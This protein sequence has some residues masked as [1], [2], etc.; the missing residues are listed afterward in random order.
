MSEYVNVSELNFKLRDEL[1]KYLWEL[2]TCGGSDLH[3]KANSIIRKRVNGEIIKIDDERFLSQSE[4][5]TLAK[6][7]L[8]GRF[9]ELVTKKSVDF[10]Y[11]PLN[12]GGKPNENYRFRVNIFFQMDGTSAV[13]RTI[14][15]QIPSLEKLGLPSSIRQICENTYRG[16]VLVTGPTGSGKSTTLASMIDFIN[17]RRKS[18]IITIEDPIEFVHSDKECVINQRS[19]GQDAID[20]ASALRGALREDPD[21]ILVG[22]MRDL[23][24]IEIAMRAAETGH[25]VLST[26]HTVDAK[27][28]IK[29]IIG[30]FPGE[31]QN[32]IRLTI[33]S[34]VKGIISQRLCKTTDHS[35]VAAIEV[36]LQTHRIS[37]LILNGK[38]EEIYDAMIES[39]KDSGMQT[40]DAHLLELYKAKR[41]TRAE[42]LENASKRDDL[43]GRLDLVDSAQRVGEIQGGAQVVADDEKVFSLKKVFD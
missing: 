22:E 7:L 19:V 15:V 5:L 39:A 41:I 32:R 36:M 17:Q 23:E 16:I 31:E 13:F 38:D 21:I 14:P 6:E 24:T 35:R 42:A 20:F 18:H 10:T 30:M 8:R 4:A 25:L 9:D 11:K 2:V 28:T 37:N 33:A 43:Q 27:D 3:L 29:R 1:D 12:L 34:V 40:F 26:L